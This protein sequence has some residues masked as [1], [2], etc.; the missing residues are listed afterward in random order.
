MNV[1]KIYLVIL[2]SILYKINEAQNKFEVAISFPASINLNKISIEY[3]NGKETILVKSDSINRQVLIHDMY[4]TDNPILMI[5]YIKDERLVNYPNR[6]LLKEKSKIVFNINSS[7]D[8]VNEKLINAIDFKDAGER[9]FDEFA[10][11]EL[12]VFNEFLL[13]NVKYFNDSLSLYEKYLKLDAVVKEKKLMFIK[14]NSNL[15]YSFWVF[16]NEFVSNT[17]YNAKR[18]LNIYGKYFSN[19][20]KSTFEGKLVLKIL[21]GRI[22]SV[23]G[24][25]APLFTANDIKGNVIELKKFRNKY[26]ILNFWASWCKPC[27][28]EM[29]ALDSIYKYCSK[30]KIAIISV[31]Q[32]QNKENCLKAIQKYQMNW[33]NIFNDPMVNN[34]YGN[35]PALPQVYLI[36]KTGKIIYSRT[37]DKDYDLNKLIGIVKKLGLL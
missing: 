26:V 1:Y 20:R 5:S 28:A 29:P 8:L 14:S 35:N 25:M 13:K 10:K 4:Y 2:F 7:G 32:D 33:M 31:S 12:K 23:K 11:K 19:Q 30:N 3:Y 18:L 17:D 24:R 27:V 9:Q 34:A 21:Q 22:N 16:K 6:Y 15:Y 37:D 36:D